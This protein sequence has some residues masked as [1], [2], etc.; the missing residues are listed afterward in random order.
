MNSKNLGLKFLFVGMLMVFSAVVLYTWRLPL[1]IDLAG[2][3]TLTY[4]IIHEQGED[5]SQDRERTIEILKQRVDPT[6]LAS[7]EWRPVGKDRF[8]VRMRIGDPK[9]QEKRKALEEA[10]NALDKGNLQHKDIVAYV[11]APADQRPAMLKKLNPEDATA[12]K[13]KKLA[14]VTDQ[15]KEYTRQLA[16]KLATRQDLVSAGAAAAATS[17]P[18]TAPAT[19]VPAATSPA[20][21][22][23]V[24]ASPLDA[25]DKEI[26]DLQDKLDNTSIARLDLQEQL[27]R[28]SLARRDMQGI[29][30]QYVPAS[31]ARGLNAAQLDQ[32][33]RPFEDRISLLK[34]DHDS[35]KGQIDAVVNAY[36]DMAKYRQ[37]LSDPDDLKRLISKA[38]QLQFRIAPTRGSSKFQ[39][40]QS[41]LLRAEESL[42]KEGPD[43]LKRRGDRFGWFPIHGDETYDNLVTQDFAGKTY[44]LLAGD[45]DTEH[46][47]L[48]IQK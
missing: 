1:G 41:D 23:A 25:I 36:K 43:G 30:D 46:T 2:G 9:V 28:T 45:K 34:L 10:M 40:S 22:Q 26:K 20:T 14:Q 12:G 44:L 39:I 5:V 17:A 21:S 19:T 42:N 31:E 16:S 27:R 13:L 8:E 29:L 3:T 32:R 48:K 47:L 4:E 37:T 35:R 7:L 38:G 18:A 15:E 24:P 33:N 11:D 6:G